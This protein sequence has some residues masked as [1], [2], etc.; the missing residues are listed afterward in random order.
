MFS[1][2]AK[3]SQRVRRIL[4]PLGLVVLTAALLP[5]CARTQD[6]AEAQ[7]EAASQ[8]SAKPAPPSS[9]TILVGS[10]ETL[11]TAPLPDLNALMQR[12]EQNAR[13]SEALIHD[14]TYTS[15]STVDNLDGHGDTRKTTTTVSDVFFID[16]IRLQRAVL[17]NGSPLSADERRKEDERVD[18]EIAKAR[19]RKASGDTNPAKHTYNVSFARFLELGSFSNERRMVFHGRNTIVLD[20]TGDPDAKTRNPLEGIIHDMAG[21]VWIDEA[22]AALCRVQGSFLRSFKIGGGLVASIAKGTAFVTDLTRVNGEVWLPANSTAQGSM[23][24]LLLFSFNGHVVTSD[25]NYR[26]FKAGSRILPDVREVDN[27]P[28]QQQAAPATQSQAAPAGPPAAKP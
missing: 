28:S 5:R 12:V 9:P 22:D 21:T 24:A 4:R 10:D 2:A 25:T 27:Q 13:R 16:G 6:R 7:A 15:T 11:S 1:L 19:E 8:L 17:R 23:R 18:K 26:K 3:P 20:F 14:Y